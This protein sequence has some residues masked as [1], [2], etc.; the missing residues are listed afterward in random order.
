MKFEIRTTVLDDGRKNVIRLNCAE[1][2]I[3]AILID[4]YAEHFDIATYNLDM[5]DGRLY[6]YEDGE[7]WT[8][9]GGKEVVRVDSVKQLSDDADVEIIQWHEYIGEGMEIENLE[10]GKPYEIIAIHEN[11][12]TIA[13]LISYDIYTKKNGKLQST[14]YRFDY[15]KEIEVSF[16]G[17]KDYGY[18]L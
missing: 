11:S 2:E 7:E 6:E 10:S 16:E 13:E 9:D 5:R 17:L 1:Y 15:G 18:A 3:E 4:F 12:V 14:G 8:E